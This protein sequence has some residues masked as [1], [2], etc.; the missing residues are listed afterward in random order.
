MAVLAPARRTSATGCLDFPHVTNARDSIIDLAGN[1]LVLTFGRV[2]A[3]AP[4]DE[5]MNRCNC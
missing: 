4:I 5:L 1:T 3:A 2:V